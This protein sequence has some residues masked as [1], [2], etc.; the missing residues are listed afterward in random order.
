MTE[1]SMTHTTPTRARYCQQC[2]EPEHRRPGRYT[3]GTLQGVLWICWHCTGKET[4]R[5]NGPNIPPPGIGRAGEFA[6][7]RGYAEAGQG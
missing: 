5:R 2:N 3:R 1:R 6:W 4:R 7:H